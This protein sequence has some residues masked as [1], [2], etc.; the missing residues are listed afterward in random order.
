VG[1]RL[2]IDRFLAQVQQGAAAGKQSHGRDHTGRERRKPAR[3][4]CG[5]MSENS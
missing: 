5:R 1:K 2:L 3:P 4:F